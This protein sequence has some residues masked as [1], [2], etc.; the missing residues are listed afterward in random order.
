MKNSKSLLLFL[1]IA[2]CSM[3][4]FNGCTQKEAQKPKPFANETEFSIIVGTDVHT[5]PNVEIEDP[6]EFS[7]TRG[8]ADVV[9]AS[10]Y[11]ENM[12]VA[13]NGV[14]KIADALKGK[15]LTTF[16]AWITVAPLL[17]G[18]I[19]PLIIA[20][21]S[22]KGIGEFYDAT[23]G[24]T[25]DERA[26]VANHFATKFSIPFSEAEHLT[27]LLV[28]SAVVNMKLAGAIKGVVKK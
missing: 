15:K 24:L 10:T 14:V 16:Q 19:K 18:E 20:G 12:A 23:Q 25:I 9:A 22:L 2:M 1:F 26:T 13:T 5:S 8:P 21:K 28:E 27:E 3:F 4:A 17:I 11:L 7:A 6:I